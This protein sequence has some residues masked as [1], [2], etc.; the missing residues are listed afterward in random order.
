MEQQFIDWLTKLVTLTTAKNYA[1][2]INIIS[3]HYSKET[4]KKTDIYAI[5]DQQCISEIA[6]DY[7]QSGKF[8]GFGY[9]QHSR[10]RAAITRYAEFFSQ[11]RD[12]DAALPIESSVASEEAA[13]IGSNFAYEKDL[14]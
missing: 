12:Q 2:A 8:S 6:H 4:G 9:E 1:K 3:E 13:A 5:S 7:S 14:R 10:F 11:H